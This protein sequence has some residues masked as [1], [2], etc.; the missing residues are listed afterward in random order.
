MSEP[1]AI[2]AAPAEAAAKRVPK[3]K[4]KSVQV[5]KAVGGAAETA[6][7][8]TSKSS[9]GTAGRSAGTL[10]LR[11]PSEAPPA[12]MQALLLKTQQA[13]MSGDVH[14]ARRLASLVLDLDPHHAPA[15]YLHGCMCLQ[16]GDTAAAASSFETALR[17]DPAHW[18]AA[19]NLATCLLQLDR[20]AEAADVASAVVRLQPTFIAGHVLHANALRACSSCAQAVGAAREARRLYAMRATQPTEEAACDSP[21]I[22]LGE[23][24]VDLA[25]E[26]M[27]AAGDYDG[28][29]EDGT[30]GGVE[31]GAV[32]GMALGSAL[33]AVGG[34]ALREAWQLATE[35]AS[36][37]DGAPM[38]AS[39]MAA[40][41][42]LAAR[43]QET[44][45]QYEAALNT[46]WKATQT[47]P[48]KPRAQQLR[49]SMVTRALRSCLRPKARDVFVA[50]YPK[51][52]TTWM[53]QVACMLAGEPADVDVQMRAPYI[54]A[55]I[56][57][58]VFSLAKLDGMRPPRIFKTH[59]AW[60]ELPVAGCTRTSPPPHVRIL[61][62]ARDPRDV[63]GESSPPHPTT[64][65]A[66]PNA[67]RTP[68][69]QP[70]L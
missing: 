48:S 56:A 30:E 34:E 13:A 8:T 50:T 62:V 19:T 18:R 68:C 63:M 69:G 23:A 61:V 70:A 2:S 66:H 26:E 32:G 14:E 36:A 16:T 27:E 21:A 42:T 22:A 57:T 37:A 52:G 3:A 15:A 1:T 5:S 20:A 24:L 29:A 46:Y 58:N 33:G 41:C 49:T 31:G 45:G 54:E 40:A 67:L 39:A 25:R 65:P 6:W 7:R 64:Q 53:Q 10:Y 59:A 9:S 35:A 38:R 47:D 51:S 55:A 4:S 60:H 43:V 44:A 28:S 17:V 11:T 12:Q